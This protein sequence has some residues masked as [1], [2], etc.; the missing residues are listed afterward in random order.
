M[1]TGDP[2]AEALRAAYVAT[3]TILRSRDAITAQHAVVNLCRALGA[4][5]GAADGNPPD[6]V[7]M[8][9]SLG[10][11]EPI[12]PVSGDPDVRA[13]LTRYLVA[14]VSDARLVV[15]RGRASE[16]LVHMA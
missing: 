6:A 7:P 16:R 1:T 12:L 13:L 2:D 15:E 5:V 3:R 10:E 11:G 8:D 14:A 4:D 9:L